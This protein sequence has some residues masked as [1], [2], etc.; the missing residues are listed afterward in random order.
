MGV[1]STGS[2]YGI[3]EGLIYSVPVQISNKTWTVVDGLEISEFSRE[4]MKATADE[5][6]EERDAALVFLP[7]KQ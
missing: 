2:H 7:S 1:L 5:L 4:K 3:P 6:V